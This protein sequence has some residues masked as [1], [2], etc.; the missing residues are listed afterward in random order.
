MKI[1]LTPPAVEPDN[2]E[3]HNGPFKKPKAK[4]S[5]VDLPG[6]PATRC[7][8]TDIFIPQ[9]L[10]YVGCTQEAWSPDGILTKAQELWDSTF[11]DL[12]H[13]LQEKDDPVSYLVRH[14]YCH[15]PMDISIT[16]F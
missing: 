9:L 16:H 5:L 6:P 12:P 3:A 8:F 2:F 14:C 11:P 4:F 15:K 7:L 10:D 13:L 1:Y